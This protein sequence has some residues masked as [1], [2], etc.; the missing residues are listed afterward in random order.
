MMTKER[1]MVP[2]PAYG[3][4]SRGQ[5]T[6]AA[7]VRPACTTTA[8]A[9]IT[10]APSTVVEDDMGNMMD[11]ATCHIIFLQQKQ[12]SSEIHQND[13]SQHPNRYYSSSSSSFAISLSYCI[14]VG[15]NSNLNLPYH[16]WFRTDSICLRFS[17]FSRNR[18]F[19]QWYLSCKVPKD[20]AYDLFQRASLRKHTTELKLQ[21]TRFHPKPAK[22]ILFW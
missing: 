14:I 20:Q 18:S 4:S 21:E 19:D 16:R 2:V 17:Q 9:A 8:T 13:I 11:I 10:V 6:D 15:T 3:H 22:V 7:T 1:Y 5:Q 12:T